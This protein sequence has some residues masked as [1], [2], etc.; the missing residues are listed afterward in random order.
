MNLTERA[1]NLYRDYLA[2][3]ADL[4]GAAPDEDEEDEDWDEDE[5]DDDDDDAEAVLD[6]DAFERVLEL[7]DAL[8][9]ELGLPNTAHNTGRL[10]ELAGE[11]GELSALLDDCDQPLAAD[12]TADDG[13]L[14]GAMDAYWAKRER[15]TLDDRVYAF[16]GLLGLPHH[17]R[18]AWP[19]ARWIHGDMALADALALIEGAD[20]PVFRVVYVDTFDRESLVLLE[21]APLVAA[22]EFVQDRYGDHMSEAGADHGLLV[23]ARGTRYRWDVTGG[24]G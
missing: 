4:N 23:D 5:D 10:E 6:E 9:L 1:L 17:A 3:T 12:V 21:G 7:E 11:W 2:A 14:R 22:I 20:S 13:A 19:L 18:N 8:L 24:G 15:K 16:E